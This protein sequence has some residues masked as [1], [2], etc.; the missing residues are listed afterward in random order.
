MRLRRCPEP[1]RLLDPSMPHPLARQGCAVQIYTPSSAPCTV[2]EKTEKD[3]DRK[4]PKR[5]RMFTGSRSWIKSSG[6]MEFPAKSWSKD[7]D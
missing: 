3:G 2:S 4:K 1:A 6:N 5:D 7:E